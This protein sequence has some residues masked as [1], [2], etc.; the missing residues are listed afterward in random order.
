M[1]ADL[2]MNVSTAIFCKVI[3]VLLCQADTVLHIVMEKQR[4][5]IKCGEVFN[6]EQKTFEADYSLNSRRTPKTNLNL[7]LHAFIPDRHQRSGADSLGKKRKNM[8]RT[9]GLQT[10]ISRLIV[11]LFADSR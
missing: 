11:Q 3:M 8:W 4:N 9:R 2:W 6:G 1:K 5:V 10:G 7:L